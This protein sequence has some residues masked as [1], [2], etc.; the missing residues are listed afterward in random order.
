[1]DEYRITLGADRVVVLP[2]METEHIDQMAVFLGDGLV[3]M[4]A[5]PELNREARHSVIEYMVERANLP[6]VA[7]RER[8]GLFPGNY[9]GETREIRTT[10]GVYREVLPSDWMTVYEASLYR[11]LMWEHPSLFDSIYS[12]RHEQHRRKFARILEREGFSVLELKTTVWHHVNCMSFVNGQAFRNRITGRPS[13]LLPVYHLPG[14]H[15][16]AF[17]AEKLSGVNAEN[18]R[19]L[20]QAGLDVIPVRSVFRKGGNLH[21]MVYNLE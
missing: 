16:D 20:E 19:I 1:M 13:I 17:S 6:A 5:L 8:I 7:M 12:Y 14:Q 21:C 2:N 15:P 10:G 11:R 9:N 18:V 3:A 4:E